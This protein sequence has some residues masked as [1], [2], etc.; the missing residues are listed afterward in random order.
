M[1]IRDSARAVDLMVGTLAA[2]GV[3]HYVGSGTSGRMGVLDA[4]ELLPTYRVGPEAVRAHL[5]GGPAAMMR[6][7]EGA[8][9]DE[10][11][12]ATLAADWGLSLIHI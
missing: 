9:D 3:A 5:A 10:A 2:G 12:G 8:E 4:V 11:A 1:C 6:A 7:V